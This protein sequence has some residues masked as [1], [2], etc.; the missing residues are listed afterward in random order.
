MQ[1]STLELNPSD[2]IEMLY[3]L[4]ESKCIHCDVVRLILFHSHRHASQAAGTSTSDIKLLSP[5]TLQPFA[6]QDI[7]LE[8]A[9]VNILQK[10]SLLLLLYF[11]N[12]TNPS[13][14]DNCSDG[15]SR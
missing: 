7:T 6:D 15:V 2:T 9:G 5:S 12:R 3:G 13:R 8:D 11:F 4:D 1:V 10:G 14:I